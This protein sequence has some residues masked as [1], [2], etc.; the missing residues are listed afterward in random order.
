MNIA[1]EMLGLTDHDATFE[2]LERAIDA[3]NRN[4]ILLNSDPI[5]API[6]DDPRYAAIVERVGLEVPDPS[7]SE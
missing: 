1:I 6:R 5:W 3:R 2:W 7:V 4:L